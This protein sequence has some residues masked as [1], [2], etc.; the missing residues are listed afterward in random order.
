MELYYERISLTKEVILILK[1]KRKFHD[2]LYTM[3]Y[4]FLYALMVKV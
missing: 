2:K 3:H 4:N 1:E